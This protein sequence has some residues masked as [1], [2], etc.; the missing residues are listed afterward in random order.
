MEYISNSPI[1]LMLTE[2]E[3]YTKTV[4]A[5]IHRSNNVADNIMGLLPRKIYIKNTSTY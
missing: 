2:M 3:G 1:I 5:V 4:F